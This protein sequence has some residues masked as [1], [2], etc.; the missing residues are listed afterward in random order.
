[1]LINLQICSEGEHDRD[2]CDMLLRM[3]LKIGWDIPTGIS[4]RKSSGDCRVALS[5]STGTSSVTV[6]MSRF[7]TVP[8]LRGNNVARGRKL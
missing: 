5:S 4:R 7:Y 2:R 6:G 1:M 3:A 8:A